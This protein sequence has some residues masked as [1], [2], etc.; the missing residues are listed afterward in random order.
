MNFCLRRNFF[1]QSREW[2]YKYVQP[3][4]IAEE[5][6]ED[7]YAKGN[8]TPVGLIDYKFFCFHGKPRLLYVSK[9]LE[10]HRTAR[11]SFTD[12]EGRVMPFHRRDYQPFAQNIVL[13]QNFEEMC[14]IAE[15]LAREIDC[16]FVRVDLYS[17][18]E[19][20][21]FSEITFTP[22][23]GTIP[24]EPDE[25]DMKLGEWLKLPSISN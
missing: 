25:W 7:E 24:F 4:I 20:V 2:A 21:F 9:G 16:P 6:V 1:D 3:R 14:K 15:R 19:N 18:N 10:D 5:F 23:G 13:P 8:E 12:M 17:V 22:C 11:I